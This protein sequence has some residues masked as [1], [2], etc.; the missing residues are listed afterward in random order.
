M[1]LNTLRG[2]VPVTSQTLG[3]TAT[4]P[5]RYVDLEI[6]LALRN[7]IELAART[8]TSEWGPIW[9]D[10]DLVGQS[11]S[12]RFTVLPSTDCPFDGMT[13]APICVDMRTRLLEG[14]HRVTLSTPIP[15]S[16]VDVGIEITATDAP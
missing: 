7:G 12:G 14:T 16:D 13:D 15:L 6:V 3:F 8:P 10:V 11:N 1:L 9:L 4:S 2:G 5:T